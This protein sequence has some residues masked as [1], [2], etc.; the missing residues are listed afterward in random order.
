MGN[1]IKMERQINKIY[2]D[3]LKKNLTQ[4]QLLLKFLQLKLNK[5]R[6]SQKSKTDRTE[7]I[8]WLATVF[9]RVHENYSLGR[10]SL[11]KSKNAT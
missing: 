9:E 1:V 11:N 7:Q 8:T 5:P 6:I 2:A 10:L 4:T 3:V